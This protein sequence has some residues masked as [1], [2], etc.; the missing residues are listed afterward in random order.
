MKRCVRCGYLKSLSD[1][2]KDNAKRDGRDPYCRLCRRD[3]NS[4]R[5]SGIS[6]DDRKNIHEYQDGKCC[7]CEE[8]NSENRLIVDFI[9]NDIVNLLCRRCKRILCFSDREAEILE[10][11]KEYL[12]F[13]YDHQYLR[14]RLVY[15]ENWQEGEEI[16]EPV[17]VVD[18]IRRF[19]CIKCDSYR[20][21]DEF[22]KDNRST[23][24][25][26]VKSYQREYRYG[27]NSDTFDYWKMEQQY[28]CAICGQTCKT[29]RELAV[30]HCHTTGKV[31]GLL[32]MLCNLLIG[33]VDD[34]PELLDAAIA[35]RTRY[36][37]TTDIN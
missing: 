20:L 17:I 23:C 32:C 22:Y 19:R 15:Q 14:I 12:V 8:L 34:N 28:G 1:F 4:L 6:L 2:N 36:P 30:D 10:K 37:V 26:C 9:D 13:F 11:S 18:G 7:M 24:I 3:Y 29:G 21:P 33:E 5:D 25:T 35:Y 16:T 27:V 31:R